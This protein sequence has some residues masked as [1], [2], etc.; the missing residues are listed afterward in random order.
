MYDRPGPRVVASDLSPGKSD[1]TKVSYP[2]SH[3]AFA[4]AQAALLSAADPARAG[5]FYDTANT[6]AFSRL[7]VAGHYPSDLV[8]GARRGFLLEA[9]QT[10]RP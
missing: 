1:P 10:R 2:S 8:A 4:Y 3:A 5:M 7:Y 6:I 9:P